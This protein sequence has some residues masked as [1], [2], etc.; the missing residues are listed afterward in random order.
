MVKIGKQQNS[1]RQVTVERGVVRTMRTKMKSN[2]MKWGL[3]TAMT[4]LCVA[5]RSFTDHTKTMKCYDDDGYDD[6]H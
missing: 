6:D 1:N 3:E 4:E 2:K 5:A